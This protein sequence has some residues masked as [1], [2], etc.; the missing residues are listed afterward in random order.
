VL[1]VNGVRTGFIVDSVTEVLRV[2]RGDLE[3]APELS[4]EQSRLVSRVANLPDSRR[5]L[6]MLEPDHLIAGDQL[7]TL[8][9][10]PRAAEA[11]A[12]AETDV[13]VG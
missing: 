6:M 12:Q 10:Q 3:P 13:L 7:G 9:P 5:M 11:E 1:I 8:I 2:T 4:P